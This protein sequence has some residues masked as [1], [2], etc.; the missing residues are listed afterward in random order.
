MSQIEL[1][2]EKLRERS[3]GKPPFGKKLGFDF[4]EGG[5][6]VLD[7]TG[8]EIEVVA[9]D[10][11]P[12]DADALVTVKPSDFLDMI[13]GKLSGQTALMTGRL[14]LKGNAMVAMKIGDILR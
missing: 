1:I 9:V 8:A 6:V 2:C 3:A 14:K 13:D 11:A 5:G 7:G 4:G 10:A 12:T